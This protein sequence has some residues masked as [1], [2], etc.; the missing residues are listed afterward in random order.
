MRLIK[1]VSFATIIREFH[2]SGRD[3]PEARE[4]ATDRTVTA[5]VE[6]QSTIHSRSSSERQQYQ[7]QIASWI[8]D[9]ATAL[10]Y[11]HNLGI[12]HRDVKP[13]NLIIDDQQK[14]WVTD[15]GLATGILN[16]T[17]TATG[18][19]LG[20]LPYMSPEQTAGGQRIVD[21]RT[22]I[23]SLGVTLFR[24]AHGTESRLQEW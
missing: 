10:H 13:A 6:S 8:R 4:P 12:V 11:A 5:S 19:L 3:N 7:K 14:V 16:T 23:Y 9:A 24:S 18:E 2:T 15:F 17:L 21:H 22:D 1:G 20:T